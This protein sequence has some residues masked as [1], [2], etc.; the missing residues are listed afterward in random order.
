MEKNRERCEIAENMTKT[1]DG[2]ER[3]RIKEG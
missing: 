1:Y 2:N 3:E